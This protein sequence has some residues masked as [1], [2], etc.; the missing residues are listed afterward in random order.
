MGA[1]SRKINNARSQKIFDESTAAYQQ[2]LTPSSTERQLQDI[3]GGS[4][5]QELRSRAMRPIQAA[6][7]GATRD[8]NRSR[9]LGT[10][11]SS[12]AFTAAMAKLNRDRTQQLSDATS[13]VNASIADRRLNTLGMLGSMEQAR[14][15]YGLSAIGAQQST[16]AN[17]GF[18]WGKLF[19]GLA[20]LGSGFLT[21]PQS[22][23]GY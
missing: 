22:S 2:S 17:Q 10:P 3:A 5:D 7:A 11:G 18:G 20:T 21:R 13:D 4:Q 8:I 9:S 23:A 12:G 14:R 1:G 15:N 16:P 6:Y 19:G